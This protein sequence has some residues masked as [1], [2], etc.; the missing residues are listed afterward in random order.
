MIVNKA[1]AE[2]QQA[3]K[4]TECPLLVI[5]GPGSGKTKTLVNRTI[6]LIKDLNVEPSS[7]FISTFTEKAANELKTRIADNLYSLNLKANLSEMYIGTLHSNFKKILEE[8][9]EYTS[10]KS[11]YR[12][13]DDF[14]QKYLIFKNQSKFSKIENLDLLTDSKFGFNFATEI[15]YYVNKVAEENLELDKLKASKNQMLV[16]L[17]DLTER[18][19]DILR[20]ENALDFSMIQVSMWELLKNEEV[21]NKLR[22]K[23]SYFMIDEYQDTNRIQE[24]ILL[25][26]AAPKNKICVVGD[27]DQSLYRFRGATIENILNFQN[28][29]KKGECVKIDLDKN[30][31][32]H[33]DIIDFYNKWMDSPYNDNSN[34]GNWIGKNGEVYRY[35]KV[36]KNAGKQNKDNTKYPGVVKVTGINE[37]EW[38]DE[39]LSFI[40]S[41]KSAGKLKDYNQLTLLS[42]S[43][44]NDKIK[45]LT[46]FLEKE[47]IPVFSPRSDMFF[48]RKEVKLVIGCYVFLFLPICKDE[49]Y[50]NKQK[51]YF[52]ECFRAFGT[53]IKK[54]E[55]KEFK[56]WAARKAQE[57]SNL[58]ENTDY[59]YSNIFY[60]LLQFSLF[61]AYL[62][63]DLSSGV[64]DLRPIYNLALFS[65]LIT[66]FEFL[67]QVIVIRP[68]NIKKDIKALFKYFLAFLIEGGIDEYED[69]DM[70]T[71]VGCVSVMTIHQ[72]KGLEF[73]ITIVDSLDSVP[74]NQIRE[75]DLI[76][77]KEYRGKEPW[78]EVSRI[79]YFDFWRLYYTAF[80]R[81]KNMLVLTCIDNKNDR[82]YRERIS[83][84]K[85]FDNVFNLAIDWKEL[86]RSNWDDLI[87]DEVKKAEIKHDYSFTSHIL[88]Y[89]NCPIQYKFFKDLEFTPVK[90]NAVLFGTLVHETI[91]NV[92]RAVLD[93]KCDLITSENI[94]IWMQD[95]Y[96]S[97]SKKTGIYLGKGGLGVVKKHIMNYVTEASKDWSSIKDAEVPVYLQ[98]EN[99]I[100]NG[101][102]DLIKGQNGCVEILD[103]KTEKKPDINSEEGREK[104]RRYRRQLEIYA[105]IIEERYGE[106]VS[107][108][109]IYY[110]GAE[111]ENPY[112]SYD[113]NKASLDRTISEVDAIVSKIENK[114]YVQN[115]KNRCKKLCG[116][117][118]LLN[119]CN[120]L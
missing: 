86:K 27:D 45:K 25:K 65:Q 120:T 98:K 72:S 110:T 41:L 95:N 13:L 1:N 29:F 49:I 77:S 3:I 79:K 100:L 76:I 59:S 112:V 26:L 33:P 21:L 107:K 109:H 119:Y 61:T 88:L 17:A 91:E 87:I 78:E 81:A 108:L 89:E 37:E 62:N 31:R 43:V 19:R 52:E 55:N 18:Y 105:H 94:E 67:N 70:T 34:T 102:I 111:D 30:Y 53:E 23:I 47:G 51:S 14:E 28:K 58:I 63:V 60:E 15:A 57:L 7:I 71:P 46:G 54:E 82:G 42:C 64:Q 66:K 36:T 68:E 83:P 40:K 103:F 96:R 75:L 92:H 106:K 115:P 10:L 2:Q 104:L 39:I 6:H 99:Y 9:R 8:N 114:I 73:P 22:N 16:V 85:Y 11:N 80:S 74:R 69:F 44:K 118:D 12:V 38:F 20:E 101:K 93:G 50:N 24:E 90:T 4:T 97:L 116:Q 5:A 56:I 84:S 48:A 113:Y 32:S 35:P 117:C